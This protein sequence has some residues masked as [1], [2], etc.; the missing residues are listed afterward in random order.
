MRP[1]SRTA[2]NAI[3]CAAV[4]AVHGE[5]QLLDAAF[6]ERDWWGLK[7]RGSTFRFRL[8]DRSRGGRLL[9]LGAGKAAASMAKGLEIVLAERIDSGLVVVKHGHGEAL[10][11]LPVIEASHPLPAADSEQ[12]ARRLLFL[13]RGLAA[14][15]CAIVLLTGGASSLLAAPADGISLEDKCAVTRQLVRSAATI[16]EINVV[17]KHLSVIKGGCLARALQPARV[18]TLAISDVLGDDPA[19]I[20][21]GPTVADPS[22]FADACAVLDRHQLMGA[23]PASISQRLRE[24]VNGAVAETPK[25]AEPFWARCQYALLAGIDDAIEA[26]AR[27]AQRHGFDVVVEATRLTG[28][29]GTRASEWAARLRTHALT[30]TP[31]SAPL[32]VIAGGETTLAVTGSGRGGRNQEF[33]A[34]VAR[35]LAGS[36]GITALV[37]GSDGTDG[38]T[39]AA[40]GFA[41]NGTFARASGRG[42]DVEAALADNDSHR[43][44]GAAGDL[45]ITGPTGTNVM[46]LAL[47]IVHSPRIRLSNTGNAS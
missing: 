35:E 43:V 45:F 18:I 7:L 8:P 47:A 40:G 26:A 44:L 16:A 39:D 11:R 3:F 38:P 25:R 10:R 36:P 17:R 19:V 4:K 24:G 27:C 42:V 23:L 15:D 32:C 28:H 12:A 1:D 21:S 37:G 41:D 9:V 22:T 2:L 46:D 30:R 33:A 13:A 34:I 5:Q 6:V 20:G 29:T 31:D 14:E